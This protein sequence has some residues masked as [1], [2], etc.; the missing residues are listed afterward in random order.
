M[1][2]AV[3]LVS[4][5]ELKKLASFKVPSHGP[6]TS[7][8]FSPDA[9]TL[10]TAAH[11][12]GG[13]QANTHWLDLRVWDIA[14]ATEHTTL[15][16]NDYHD[17]ALAFSP[18]GRRLAVFTDR[19]Q[20]QLWDVETWKIVRE[21]HPEVSRG[22]AVG[23]SP[24]GRKLAL[25]TGEHGRIFETGSLVQTSSV[26]PLI[27]VWATVFSPDLTLFAAPNYQDVDLWDTGTGKVR[28]VLED[29]HGS[30]HRLA[31][32]A[33]GKVL[34][35]SVNREDA[36]RK[37]HGEV[38]LW[39]V[40]TGKLLTTLRNHVGFVLWLA[41]SPNGKTV[42]VAGPKD[43]GG[44]QE[45]KVIEVATGKVRASLQFAV[46]ESLSSLSLSPDGKRLAIGCDDRTVRLYDLH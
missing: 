31:F 17:A 13:R 44:P 36:D 3:Y 46:E 22:L 4:A 14:T 29:H 23:F 38:V 42:V 34:A 8:T 10:V 6:V 25:A 18:D 30:V 19:G 33:D 41:I 21:I 27:R 12:Y 16:I 28:H 40:T 45:L 7:L 15:R 39:D 35:V 26:R 32:T 5:A 24:D 1:F 9:K 37:Y 20:L 2:L 43:L 11:G